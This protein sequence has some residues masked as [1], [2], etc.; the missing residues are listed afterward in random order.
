MKHGF[1]Q[2]MAGVHT[3]SGLLMGWL[4]FVMFACGTCAYFQ[5]E[6]T[7][8]MQPE[9]KRTG[10]QES[11]AEGAAAYLATVAAGSAQWYIDLPG[12]RGATTAL[13]WAPPEGAAPDA[14]TQAT[15]DDRGQP[16]TARETAGGFFLYRF[17]FDL[18]YMPVIWAR[19]IVGAAAMFMLVAILSGIVTHKKIFTDFFLLRF[20]KGQR[21]WLDAHNVTAVLALPFHL[22]ITYTGLV[23]LD[24]QLA[25]AP[26][27]ALY[28]DTAAWYADAFPQRDVVKT[29]RAV[30]LA[31]LGP[32]IGEA[33]K[34]WDGAEV[35][36]IVIANPGDA[37]S[38]VTI[39]SSPGTSMNARGD[40]LQFSGST[41]RML[42]AD[43]ASGPAR[44][45]QDVM[46]GIHA[47]RYADI[48]LRWLYFLSG[49]G[50]TVMVGTGLVLWTVKRR[51][52]LPDPARPHVGF[53]IV[54]RLNI[55]VVAGFPIG[56]ACYFLANRLLPLRMDGRPEWEIHCLF[57]AW[58][59][60]A[61]I[62]LLRPARHAWIELAGLGAVAF[63]AVP[64]V[65]ALTT[66]RGLPHSLLAGDWL[67][68]GFD[69]T[70]LATAAAFGLTAWTLARRA[71]R[72]AATPRRR[73]EA[74]A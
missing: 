46:I 23:T 50:G 53:R 19:Y 69:L 41:G 55:A 25:P 60:A 24:S 54:E 36:P 20:G 39:S 27:A 11:A 65:S 73:W 64:V 51:A 74:P 44:Q 70:C 22:M 72:P 33:R 49:V 31:P 13:Y 29:G 28:K 61:T 37:S 48:A 47:G 15:V 59:V 3:W 4:L 62:A 58:V 43:R 17:H 18:H 34:R 16:V 7:R 6:I 71:S 12:R 68:I 57:I 9:V 21:S 63:A 38:T 26:V 2:S 14:P 5:L 40:T 1:R 56:L 8:W 52:K 10:T 30:P 42:S 67:F 32:M 45:T 35:R 66:G